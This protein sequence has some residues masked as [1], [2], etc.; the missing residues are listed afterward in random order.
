MT[1]IIRVK[2]KTTFIRSRSSVDKQNTSFYDPA[3]FDTCYTLGEETKFQIH[4][5]VFLKIRSRSMCVLRSKTNV[6]QQVQFNQ[7]RVVE[8]LNQLK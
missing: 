3:I 1:Q 6:G 2:N 7:R 4:Y 5:E 8:Y